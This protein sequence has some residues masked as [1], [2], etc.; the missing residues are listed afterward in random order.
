[1]FNLLAA[2][3]HKNSR[4]RTDFPA[5]SAYFGEFLSAF[6]HHPPAREKSLPQSACSRLFVMQ[7]SGLTY[8]FQGSDS[9]DWAGGSHRPRGSVRKL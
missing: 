4:W 5:D 2:C 9:M 8:M 7:L 6:L 1:M 3:F